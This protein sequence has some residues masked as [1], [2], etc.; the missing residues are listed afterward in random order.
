MNIVKLD[1]F[2][3]LRKAASEIHACKTERQLANLYERKYAGKKGAKVDQLILRMIFSQ[4]MK[5][6]S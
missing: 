4:R 3:A 5:E 1:S 2:E 6:V